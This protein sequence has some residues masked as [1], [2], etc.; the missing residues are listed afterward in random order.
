MNRQEEEAVTD[1]SGNSKKKRKK[2]VFLDKYEEFRT[3]TNMNIIVL[4]VLQA[5]QI[6]A[7]I[8]TYMYK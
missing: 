8:A 2:Y 4:Y 7:L 3:S 6:L 5:L 1:K